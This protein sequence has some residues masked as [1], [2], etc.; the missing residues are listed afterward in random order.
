MK[1]NIKIGNVVDDGQ[2]DYLRRGGAKINENFDE[3][4]YELG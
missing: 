3:L 2:G 4:Y 1:Q